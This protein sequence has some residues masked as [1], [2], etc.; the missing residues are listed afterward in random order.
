MGQGS[1]ALRDTRPRRCTA[2]GGGRGRLSLGALTVSIAPA[3]PA[4]ETDWR[5]LEARAA[6]SFFNTWC[7]AATLI[8][9]GGGRLLAATVRDDDGAVAMGLL[10]PMFETRH[11][12][13]SVRQLRLN[14]IV[15]DADNFIFSEFTQILAAPAREKEAWAALLAE[16][17]QSRM[18]RWDEIIVSYALADQECMLGGLGL[19]MHRRQLKRSGYVDLGALRAKGVDTV[20]AYVA[21]L[22]KTTKSQISRSMKL[23][24]ES[25]PLRLEAARS[26]PEAQTWFEEI[27]RLQTDKRR[28][29]GQ[30]GLADSAFSLKFHQ[31]LIE[32]GFP[33]GAVELLRASAGDKTFAWLFNFLN[34]DQVMFN[35][36]GLDL[37]ADNRLKPGLVS[38]ALAVERYLRAGYNAYDFL[39]G[40]ERYKTSL[41]VEGPRFVSVALQ[42]PRVKLRVED[43]LRWVKQRLAH[44]PESGAS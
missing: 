18:I 31:K 15:T 3:T 34:R 1:A 14:E 40:D 10:W 13:L 6:P 28:K 21:S 30:R 36:A 17:T 33:L 7:W 12:V 42:R 19:R 2:P 43:G 41:G 38:H 8:E 20:A 11:R 4:L 23:Y 27:I 26:E 32:R 44:A 25:G 22:G 37:A 39:A 35:V 24:A 29:R 16:L 5:A 9:M